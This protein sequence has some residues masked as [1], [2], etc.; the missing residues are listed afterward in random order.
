MTNDFKNK[1]V[2]YIS[3]ILSQEAGNNEP[4]FNDEIFIENNLGTYIETNL[5]TDQYY[6]K[7]IIQGKTNDG[8]DLDLYVVYGNQFTT[9][10]NEYGFIVILD[11]KLQPL[12]F[13]N[14]YS[15]GTTFE[16]I[17]ILN[18]DETGKLYGIELVD[19]ND[20]PRQRIILLNN[21]LIKN[22]QQLN[23]SITLRQ[24]YNLPSPINNSRSYIGIA[25]SPFDANYLL[26]GTDYVR[27]IENTQLFVETL[28]IEVGTENV[29]NSYTYQFSMSNINNIQLGTVFANWQENDELEFKFNIYKNKG[30][31][32][33]YY[34]EYTL[35][36]NS[37]VEKE[38]QIFSGAIYDTKTVILNME[39]TY[40]N[41]N[42][43]IGSANAFGIFKIDYENNTAI[44]ILRE[45]GSS[46][47]SGYVGLEIK[48]GILFYMINIIDN[49][50]EDYRCYIGIIDNITAYGKEIV[51]SGEDEY[52]QLII[53]NTYN[54]FNIC[55]ISNYG[56]NICVSQLIYNLNNYNGLD[57]ENTNSLV[58]H[59][60][61][62]YD[63]DNYILFARNLY[64]K[65][66]NGNITTS[67]LEIPN[68]MLN[69]NIIS[70]EDLISETNTQLITN[71]ENIEKNIY[72]TVYVNFINT[73]IMQNQ[74]DILNPIINQIGATRINQSVSHLKDYGMAKATK[75]WYNYSDDT[76]ASYDI[77]ASLT[78]INGNTATYNFVVYVPS[79]KTITSIELRS[80]DL[81]TT[82]ITI[83][84]SNLISGKL[85]KF[86]QDVEVI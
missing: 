31:L 57:Y 83:D 26:I 19:Q 14:Q 4:Q 71:E 36:N 32:G 47:S 40:I 70:K 12:Q 42:Y 9:S 55:L 23:Y 79:N 30:S 78:T 20:I 66:I 76:N 15:S 27:N 51:F 61:T 54:L 2:K 5:G 34:D 49:E 53:T 8:K 74:N 58:P 52:T 43:L 85:Y 35:E 17:M 81:S 62:L 38:I 16:N 29:W 60:A 82:Y 10:I 39:D 64:N 50:Y 45:A 73:L 37:L 84:T 75:L 7:D 18:I 1:L 44:A 41:T 24:S 46:Y 65:T 22:E 56:N 25:K 67:T 28:K 21:F 13:I 69:E 48:N 77:D 63:N 3:G 68:T 33:S 11:N 86:T 59:S 80:A 72:E 6:I